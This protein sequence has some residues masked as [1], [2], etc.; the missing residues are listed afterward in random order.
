MDDNLR[1]RIQAEKRA[2]YRRLKGGLPVPLAGAVYWAAIGCAGYVL[3]LADWVRLTLW[4]SGLIFPLAV[5]LGKLLRLDFMK[6]RTAV[7]DVV[8][9]AL[10]SML[11]IFPMLTAAIW[12]EPQLMPL[13]FAIGTAIMWPVTGWA[14]GRTGLYTAHAIVRTVVVFGIWNW[15]PEG[16]FTVLPLSVSAIYLLTIA[17]ILIDIRSMEHSA[18][19][20][21]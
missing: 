19:A 21:A 14:Y 12:T 15:F 10:I 11:L 1:A 18:Q 3:P 8:L 7:S 20:T 17:V 4:C 16:R 2:S 6:D 5:L 9:P 13:I